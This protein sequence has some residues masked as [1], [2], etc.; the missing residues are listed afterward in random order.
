MYEP[1][2]PALII[3][4]S[5]ISLAAWNDRVGKAREIEKT[6]KAMGHRVNQ[7]MSINGAIREYLPAGAS[8]MGDAPLG[9][10][11]PAWFRGTH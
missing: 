7:G 5:R 4:K 1:T 3:V 10:L 11:P 8:N 9:R 6:M 2:C